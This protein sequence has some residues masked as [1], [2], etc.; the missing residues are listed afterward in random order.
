MKSFN[1]GI[2]PGFTLIHKNIKHLMNSE[3]LGEIEIT[4]TEAKIIKENLE[5]YLMYIWVR[6]GDTRYNRSGY[7]SAFETLE[8]LINKN[9]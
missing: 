7:R 5:N 8:N 4:N 9:F 6:L 3:G 2:Q 1:T